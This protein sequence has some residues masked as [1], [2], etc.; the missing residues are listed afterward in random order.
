MRKWLSSLL[1]IIIYLAMV[2]LVFLYTDVNWNVGLKIV[3]TVIT[4][5]VFMIYQIRPYRKKTAE[6]RLNVLMGG[7]VLM[8]AT[9]IGIL[10]QSV[11]LIKRFTQSGFQSEELIAVCVCEIIL[12][13][14]IGFLMAVNGFIRI[15]MTA[16]QL[17]LV[18]RILWIMCWWLPPINLF[19]TMYVYKSAEQQGL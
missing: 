13:I 3:L 7:N 9:C 18:W 5:V 2:N 17:K 15:M 19:I 12:T 11:Y 1:G 4:I 8:L 10:I 6:T 14:G 16:R